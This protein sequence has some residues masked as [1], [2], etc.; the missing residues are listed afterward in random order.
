VVV[1]LEQDFEGV[2]R[3]DAEA[4]TMTWTRERTRQ[5]GSSHMW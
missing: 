3:E 1:L 4:L 2:S 5:P